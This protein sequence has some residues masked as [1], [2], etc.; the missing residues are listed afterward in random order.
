MPLR[1]HHDT[2]S[3]TGP[4]ISGRSDDTAHDSPTVSHPETRQRIDRRLTIISASD[5]AATDDLV[6]TFPHRPGVEAKDYD[7]GSLGIPQDIAAML[8][9][10]ARYYPTPLAYASQG[11]LWHQITQFAR[12]IRENPQMRSAA[13]VNTAMVHRYRTWLDRQTHSR[14][15]APWA[16]SSRAH[17]LGALRTLIDTAK[18]VCPERLPSTIVF[19]AHLYAH[20]NPPQVRR[21][22]DGKELKTLTWCCQKEIAEI[23]TR[24]EIAQQILNEDNSAS[25]NP[26]LVDILDALDRLNNTGS[27][28]SAAMEHEMHKRGIKYGTVTEHGGL[29]YLQSYLCLTPDTAA[30]FYVLLLIE[31]AG[32]VEP[33]RLLTRDCRRPDPVDDQKIAIEWE[34]ARSGRAPQRTQQRSFPPNKQYAPPALVADLLTLTEPL[35]SLVSPGDQNRLFLVWRTHEKTFGMIPY[36]TLALATHRFL[37]R[38]AIHID[39]WNR[40]HPKRQRPPLPDFQLRDLRGSAATKHYKNSRGDIRH[41]QRVLNHSSADTTDLYIKGPLTQDL[42]YRIIASLMKKWVDNLCNHRAVA[43]DGTPCE[44]GTVAP[45]ASFGNECRDPIIPSTSGKPQLCPNFQ[46]CLDCPGLVIPIDAKHYA[47]LLRA[48]KAFES[49]LQRLN[50]ERFRLFYADSYRRLK[51]ILRQFPDSLLPEAQRLL[52]SLSR[53]PELE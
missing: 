2:Y 42:N 39:E 34:K 12:F 6:V 43:G 28:T 4:L 16:E 1:N 49:A 32:N 17:A 46:K 31:L 44:V 25:Q 8:A 30:P 50:A 38:A 18:R 9:H 41:V 27:P 53:L 26:D 7:F 11:T 48:E 23:R 36:R 14:T 40:Q 22:L 45:A 35:V 24:F 51:D 20:R 21:G 13:D 19:P 15:G 37:S 47:L 52:A 10:A 3:G 33:V 5:V 29:Q